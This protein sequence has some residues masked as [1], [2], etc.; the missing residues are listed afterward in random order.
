MKQIET[1]IVGGGPAGTAT[2]CGLAS[3]GRE[4]MLVER[5]AAPH[6]KVCG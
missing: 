6:H 5:A 3:M 2:A 4:G 1:I